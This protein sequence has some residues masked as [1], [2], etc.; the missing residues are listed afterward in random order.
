MIGFLLAARLGDTCICNGPPAVICGGSSSVMIGGMPAA[1]FQ[2]D[3]AH[4]GIIVTG[5]PSVFIGG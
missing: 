5:C 4:G 2:D 1:R 3:T